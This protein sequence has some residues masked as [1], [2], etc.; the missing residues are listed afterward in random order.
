MFDKDII[1][2]DEYNYIDEDYKYQWKE[3]EKINLSTSVEK[4]KINGKESF[5][6]NLKGLPDDYIIEHY[7][8]ENKKILI[9]IFAYD[10]TDL[11]K[12]DHDEAANSDIY[13]E[14]NCNVI[15]T[16]DYSWS[17]GNNKLGTKLYTRRKIFS[18]LLYWFYN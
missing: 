2:K 17:N 11:N 3:G 16:N 5:L 4:K 13:I 14:N 10:V 7:N 1:D 9:K 18:F 8:N 6:I 15:K 12:S